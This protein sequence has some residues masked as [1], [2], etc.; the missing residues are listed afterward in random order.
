MGNFSMMIMLVCML[1]FLGLVIYSVAGI[2][3]L[4]RIL[5]S[6]NR[7][8]ELEKKM[9]FDALAVS[10]MIMITVNLVQLF[11]SF[12]AP[13]E[14]KG[15]VSPGLTSNGALISFSPLHIDSFLFGCLVVGISNRFRRYHFG[16]LKRRNVFLPIMI[17]L[18]AVFVPIIM[19]MFI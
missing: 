15:I 14:W 7:H 19:S 3:S 9:V 18:V 2:F 5:I 10:M 16:L 4:V 17:L 1:P 8:D 12:V 13:L 11:L 6:S